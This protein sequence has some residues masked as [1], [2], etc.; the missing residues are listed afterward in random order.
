MKTFL[1]CR[2][3]WWLSEF[4]RLAPNGYDPTGPLRS[5][6][7]VHAAL[8]AVYTPGQD[9][10]HALK[11]AQ[12]AD[13]QT[14]VSAMAEDGYEA[15]SAVAAEFSKDC[16]LERIMLEGYL[17]WVSEEGED[18]DLDIL[19]TEEIVTV[20]A[21]EFA[22][23]LI[24]EYWE[25]EVVGKMDMRLRRRSDGARLFLD[26]KTSRNLNDALPTLHMDPQM[27][28]YHWL[29][30]MTT[31]GAWCDGALY[32]VL[33]KVKRTKTAK[34]PFFARYEVPHNAHEIAAYQARMIAVIREMFRLEDAVAQLPPEEAAM[35]AYPTP[36]RDCSWDCQFFQLCPLFDDG[37]RAEDMVAAQFHERDPLARYA[38]EGEPAT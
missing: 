3:K 25:F 17:Q 21:S 26:H 36:T 24:E 32:N 9:P 11:V 1:R 22:P 16:D 33:K 31:D 12:D 4:R 38:T 10:H 34:P 30:S 15:D 20:H 28:H 27:L 13:W 7:R 29:E 2:R 19:S 14:Y 5:G 37:S 18:A 35:A 23:D 6:S 8:E